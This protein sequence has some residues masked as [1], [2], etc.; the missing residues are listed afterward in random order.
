MKYVFELVLI[1]YIT[2]QKV[3][4]CR[5]SPPGNYRVQRDKFLTNEI[6]GAN[7]VQRMFTNNQR[8]VF[9]AAKQVF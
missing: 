3:I 1:S 2:K 8:F 4:I 5:D 9:E 7:S 6:V